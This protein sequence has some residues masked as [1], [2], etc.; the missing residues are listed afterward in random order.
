MKPEERRRAGLCA[1]TLLAVAS[2]SCFGSGDKRRAHRLGAAAAAVFLGP[3][4]VRNCAWWG[5]VATTF[6]A[7][8]REVWLTIDDGP[9][10]DETPRILDTLRAFK[11]RATFFCIGQRVAMNPALARAVVDGGHDVQNHTFSHPAFTFWA[12][13]P[14][15][16]AEEIR[17][18]SE[19]IRHAT[20]KQPDLFRAP[21]GLANAFVHAAAERA[22]LKMI[23]WSAAGNDGIAHDREK[24]LR[25]ILGNARPG[26]IILLHE[27]RLAGLAPGE[28]ARTLEKLIAGLDGLR[29]C[30]V[31][32]GLE[33]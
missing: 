22:K 24:V 25:R 23:G 17:A 29:L 13:L 2:A 4:L 12:A 8:E 16:A 33:G 9:D 28:R 15:R 20:G 6:A 11:A 21:A 1:S 14:R 7:R 31:I 26:S 27:N 18:G 10:P 32:P 30:P 3:T 19:A 5:P